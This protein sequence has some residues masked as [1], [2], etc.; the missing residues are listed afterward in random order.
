MPKMDIVKHLRN[1]YIKLSFSSLDML[2][3][4]VRGCI[5]VILLD[6]SGFS[7][8]GNL[9]PAKRLERSARISYAYLCSFL[10][11]VELIMR[12]S[13]IAT[14]IYLKNNKQFRTLRNLFS[15]SDA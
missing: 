9:T 5:R 14:F 11:F 3:Q 2:R 7:M 10:N 6:H 15:F 8:P 12:Q 1:N 4:V 13:V